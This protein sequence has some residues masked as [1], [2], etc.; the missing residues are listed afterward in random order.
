MPICRNIIVEESPRDWSILSILGL[1]MAGGESIFEV[2][3]LFLVE[4]IRTKWRPD[5]AS[6]YVYPL[7]QSNLAIASV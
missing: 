6:N 7:G 4:N 5:F 2:A 1:L 3:T